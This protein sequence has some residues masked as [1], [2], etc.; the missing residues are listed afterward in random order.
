MR[1]AT[2]ASLSVIL[3][4]AASAACGGGGGGGG[5]SGIFR[6]SPVAGLD[7]TTSAGA[8]GTSDASGRFRFGAGQSV[9]FSIGDVILGVATGAAIVTP[10][11]LAPGASDETDETVINLARFLQT[12]DLDLDPSNGIVVDELV[13]QAAVGVTL[14]FTQSVA[15]FEANEGAKVGTLTAGLPGGARALIAAQAA[16]D[17]LGT[18]LR[19]IVAG[20]YDGRFSGDDNGS[21]SVYVNRAGQ[22]FGWA[23]SPSDGVL[24]L[25]GGAETDGGF[26]AGNASSGATFTGQIERDGTL[27]GTWQ[28]APDDGT[29]QGTRT[30]SLADDLDEALIDALAG[31][32]T[33]T[34]VTNEGSDPF[35]LFIDAD[36]NLS[37]PPADG[38]IGGS[39]VATSGTSATFEAIDVE[40]GEVRGT[41]QASG[42]ISG[43]LVNDLTGER[44]TISGTKQ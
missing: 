39:I 35:T 34:A 13:R 17:H 3:S 25:D 7:Y 42:A 41:L 21:F 33:G 4:V 23:V 2:R 18:T 12:L 15:A 37:L 32:Y 9:T 31:T 19:T 29:F 24:A 14:D 5:P 26:L 44:G 8:R 40:G 11:D 20:R 38:V 30:T 36:G 27:A 43:S 28:L 22:L 6:D 10:V 16:Q 1:S